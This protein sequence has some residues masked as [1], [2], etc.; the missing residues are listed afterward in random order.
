MKLR[1]HSTLN[2]SY[3]NGPGNRFVIWTQGCNLKCPGCF[4]PE[5]HDHNGGYLIETD[6]L[7]Q[8][9]VSVKGIEGISVSGGEPM[10]QVE[11]FYE[12][13]NRIRAETN[14]SVLIYSGF[15]Y[16]D[17]K[18]DENKSIVLDI[19]DIL[20][21]GRY[22]EQLK[23]NRSLRSSENQKIYFYTNRYTIADLPDIDG[24]I[25]IDDK[26]KVIVSGVSPLQF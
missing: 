20:I 21:V 5:T 13:L 4:N 11:A 9:I 17:I 18:K 12:L 16:E 25:V 24:E 6:E 8:Q 15:D 14:L 7:F 22:D 10:L 23:S 2:S 3:S 1:L 19:C 26:G